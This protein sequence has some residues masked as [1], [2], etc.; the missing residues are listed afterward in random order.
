MLYYTRMRNL[1]VTK[2]RRGNYLI[3]NGSFRRAASLIW[4]MLGFP[5]LGTI[6]NLVGS[7]C[8]SDLI[9]FWQVRVEGFVI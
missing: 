5:L 1:E 6:R 3:F 9:A 2:G 7:M 8:E 4:G